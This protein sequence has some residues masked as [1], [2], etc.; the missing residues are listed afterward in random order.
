M[1]V[2]SVNDPLSLLFGD[3]PTPPRPYSFTGRGGSAGAT[4]NEFAEGQIHSHCGGDAVGNVVGL[5]VGDVVGV[6]RQS[7][8]RTLHMHSMPAGFPVHVLGTFAQRGPIP[9]SI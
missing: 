8:S 3:A 2:D 5:V 9:V 7:G 1:T 4:G 6:V